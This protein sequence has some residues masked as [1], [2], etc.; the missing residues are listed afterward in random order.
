MRIGSPDSEQFNY[1]LDA[2]QNYSVSKRVAG[3]D[4]TRAGREV[5]RTILSGSITD[6]PQV[7]SSRD[8]GRVVRLF[9]A[10]HLFCYA[11]V[12]VTELRPGASADR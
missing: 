3:Y 10:I 11:V 8:V 7:E 5:V 1:H 6:Q 9:D 4:L 12:L 2:L